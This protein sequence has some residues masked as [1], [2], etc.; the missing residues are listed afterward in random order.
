MVILGGMLK[1]AKRKDLALP[2]VSYVQETVCCK[3]HYPYSCTAMNSN[4]LFHFKAIFCNKRPLCY[5][6]LYRN[7]IT[8]ITLS[9][10]QIGHANSADPDQMPQN[11][12]SDL[13]LH[14]LPLHSALLD[15]STYSKID[16]FF[17]KF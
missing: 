11:A 6:Q 13:G 4:Y 12:A 15:T 9:I 8:V 5:I 1:A 14:C 17:F 3:S 16:F 2:F 10:G 7:L